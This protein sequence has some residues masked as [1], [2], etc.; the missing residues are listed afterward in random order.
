M[1]CPTC[2]RLRLAWN[3]TATRLE[4]VDVK[5]CYIPCDV[6]WQIIERDRESEEYQ[7]AKAEYMEHRR[8]EH[9]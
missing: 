5:D 9:A 3:A 6:A 2:N 4:V 1:T 7:R 8:V